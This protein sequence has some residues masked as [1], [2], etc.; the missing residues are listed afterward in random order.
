VR[1]RLRI[2][3]V[4]LVLMATMFLIVGTAF[5]SGRGVRSSDVDGGTLRIGTLQFPPALNPFQPPSA[6]GSTVLEYMYPQIVQYDTRNL[7]FAPYF[8]KSWK[9]SPNGLT[10][11]FRTVANAKWSDGQ[12]LTADDAAW[13]LNTAIKWLD[14]ATAS[15]SA[16]V[17]GVKSASAPNATTLVL[18]MA[19]RVSYLLSAMA[20]ATILPRHVWEQYATKDGKGL[21]AYNN[22][23]QDGQ[24]IVSGGPFMVTKF[25]PHQIV[26]A[27]RNPN[28]WGRKPHIDGW[29]MQYFSTSAAEIQ[30]LQNGSLDFLNAYVPPTA[31]APLK[32]KGFRVFPRPNVEQIYL[33][34]NAQHSKRHSEFGD[35]LVRKAFAYAIDQ[36]AIVR[37]AYLGYAR[38][39]AA[40]LSTAQGNAPGTHTPWVD[41]NLR[42]LPFN[43]ATANRILDKAGYA[44][45]SNGVRSAHGHDM[46]YT[47]ILQQ[48]NG[49]A[50][51]RTFEIV[52]AAFK[53]IGVKVVPRVMDFGA[54][55][56]AMFANKYSSFDMVFDDNG[57]P[58]DPGFM[59]ISFTCKQFYGLND[60]GY[61]HKEWDAMYEQQA[62]ARTPAER[63]RIVRQMQRNFFNDRQYISVVNP[64]M[65]SVAG[66]KFTGYVPGPTRLI[67]RSSTQT[68]LEVHQV[69]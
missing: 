45:G 57:G 33:D 11:T 39:T 20:R 8:A 16:A 66:P 67:Y 69:K 63:V 19:H 65:I 58:I 48:P 53:K 6:D 37:T 25:V 61:C 28:W 32:A 34:I 4:G 56:D 15:Y 21:A 42:P 47:I 22:V 40:L 9:E 44:R 64:D 46:S 14:G 41:P 43:I 35:P 29:G 10:W 24:P 26:L 13:T 49:A 12:P 68:L 51:L 50:G 18:H 7:T 31:V 5:A 2:I 1:F 3:G 60:A 17:P 23:P 62:V 55:F 52:Q 27:V 59:L 54:S 30:A 36:K 38:P